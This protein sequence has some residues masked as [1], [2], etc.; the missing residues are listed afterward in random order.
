MTQQYKV[1]LNAA[2]FDVDGTI[3]ISQPAI[4]AFW[5]EFGKDKP[6]FDA[7]YVI[8]N[9]HGMRTFDV[10]SK[11]ARDFAS[12]EYVNTLE[13]EI[14]DR[15]GS[16]AIEVIGSVKLCEK[17]NALP[18]EK[19]AVATSGTFEMARKWFKI[20]GIERP[21]YFI[22]ANDVHNGKPHPEPYIRG[23]TGLGYPPENKD[24]KVVVF[25]DAPAGATAGTAAGCK[26]IGLATTYPVEKLIE[27]GCDMVIKDYSNVEIGEYDPTTDTVEFFFNDVLYI[28]DDMK[29]W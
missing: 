9:S 12:R 11:F 4:A 3:I 17:L 26:V 18:K 16:H 6:Y 14:P 1:K 24:A 8:A 19:W 5:R 21:H 10:I 15:F 25:E 20:L 22:T 28:K 29:N 27:F 23:R 13:S 2:L 7:E